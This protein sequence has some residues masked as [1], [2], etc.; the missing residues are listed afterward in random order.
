MAKNLSKLKKIYSEIVRGFSLVKMEETPCYLKHP[1]TIESAEQEYLHEEFL[2]EALNSGIPTEE[3]REKYLIS[4]GLW[5][6]QENNEIITWK[7]F[8]K[9]ATITKSKLMLKRDIDEMAKQ[10]HDAEITLLSLEMQKKDRIGFTAEYFA[11]SRFNSHLIL[12]SFFYDK[13]FKEKVFADSDVDETKV[14]DVLKLYTDT[15]ASFREENLKKIAIQ[16]FF[17]NCFYLCNDDVWKYY[18]KPIIDLT[19]FQ[20]SLYSIGSHY[21]KVL[22]DYQGQPTE[23]ELE[24]PDLLVEKHQQKKNIDQTLGPESEKAQ[25]IVGMTKEDRKRAGITDAETI[26]IGKYVGKS[27]EEIAR[28]YIS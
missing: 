6:E 19:I 15:L 11:N 22:A 21:K 5:S 17:M 20:I 27:F 23:E 3:E 1:S 10:L 14:Y 7:E 25:S 4:V 26:K 2:Q 16:P 18:G 8:I 28:D 24:N 13:A 12:D 9:T